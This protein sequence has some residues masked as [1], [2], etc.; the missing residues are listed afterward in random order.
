VGGIDNWKKKCRIPWQERNTKEVRSSKRSSKLT[1]AA[2]NAEGQPVNAFLGTRCHRPPERC[3]AITE[4]G[5][6]C[7]EEMV[8]ARRG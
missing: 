3:V 5:A 7:A 8:G 6:L 1:V 2:D 4:R